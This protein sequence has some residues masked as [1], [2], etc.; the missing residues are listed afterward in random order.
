LNPGFGVLRCGLWLI[1]FAYGCEFAEMYDS[2]QSAESELCIALCI[3]PFFL[4]ARKTVAKT[5]IG[6]LAF[7]IAVK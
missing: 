2:L 3:T 1:I 7:Q 4:L 5:V 6:D